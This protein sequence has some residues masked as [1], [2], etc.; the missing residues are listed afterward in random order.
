MARVVVAVMPKPEIPPR[1]PRERRAAL[2][3]AAVAGKLDVSTY[4][5]CR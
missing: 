1:T 3:T 2:I 5:R 4:G